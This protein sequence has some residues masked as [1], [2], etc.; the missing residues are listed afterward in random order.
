MIRNRIKSPFPINSLCKHISGYQRTQN[1]HK[2]GAVSKTVPQTPK[3]KPPKCS[4]HNCGIFILLRKISFEIG[5]T[6]T[7]KKVFPD[8]WMAILICA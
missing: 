5:L 7:L 4:A 3:K 2:T 1:E 6:L 8:E